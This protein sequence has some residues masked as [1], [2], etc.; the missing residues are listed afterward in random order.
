M[1]TRLTQ[2]AVWVNSDPRRTKVI[3][4]IAIA[5]LMI[6][7]QVIPGAHVLAGP[8]GGGTDVGGL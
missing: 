5:A 4:A 2:M 3:T 7:T 6:A 8:M 1:K